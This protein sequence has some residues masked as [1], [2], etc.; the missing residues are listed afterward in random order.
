MAMPSEDELGNLLVRQKDHI[1]KIIDESKRRRE[2]DECRTILLVVREM[3]TACDY[4]YKLRELGE[5]LAHRER[6]FMLKDE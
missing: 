3:W 1:I 2:F 6:E 5:R 4:G